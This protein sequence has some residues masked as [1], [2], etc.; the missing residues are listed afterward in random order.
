MTIIRKTFRIARGTALALG[1]AVILALVFGAVSM[2]F[3]RD[4]DPWL[5]GRTNVATA[6]TSL[7]GKLGVNGPIV[8]ITNNNADRND[9]ALDLRVQS[10]EPPM[11]V[12]SAKKVANLNADRLD[13]RDSSAFAG[14]GMSDYE[15]SVP[16]TG[17]NN[18]VLASTEISPSRPALVYASA[19]SVFDRNNGTAGGV[20]ELELR[21]ATETNRV[22]S[23]GNTYA[24]TQSPQ[25]PLSTQG[26]LVSNSDI[27]DSSTPLTPFEVTPGNTYVLRLVGNATDDCTGNTSMEYIALSYQLIGK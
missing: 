16:L 21:D 10:G 6:I 4:G 25:A 7:G 26:V 23:G 22:A 27:Y 15:G 20:L 12:N 14:T 1:V 19:T 5:L 11:R 17:C 9:T 18:T 24:N 8:R 3:A 2:A 13:N